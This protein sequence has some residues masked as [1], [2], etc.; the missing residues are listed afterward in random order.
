MLA[1]DTATVEGLDKEEGHPM[2]RPLFMQ[3][4]CG[5]RGHA[6]AWG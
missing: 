1:L 3:L 2:R 6:V 5:Q 4:G